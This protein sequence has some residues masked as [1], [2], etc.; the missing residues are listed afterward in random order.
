[1]RSDGR[2]ETGEGKEVKGC[3][4]LRTE[5]RVFITKNKWHKIIIL[6]CQCKW[7]RSG[8]SI[9]LVTFRLRVRI[10]LRAICKQP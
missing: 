4:I 3:E 2:G 8:Y 7:S 5:Q 6:Q 1:M 10:S 9:G